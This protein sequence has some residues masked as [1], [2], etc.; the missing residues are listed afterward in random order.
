[1]SSERSRP[2]QL[3]VSGLPFHLTNEK[4]SHYFS[5]FGQI[6]KFTRPTDRRT[7]RNASYAFLS[8]HDVNIFESVRTHDNHCVDG[9]KFEVRL[10]MTKEEMKNKRKEESRGMVEVNEETIKKRYF[11]PNMMTDPW[12]H[13]K[14]VQIEKNRQRR[15]QNIRHRNRLFMRASETASPSPPP[16]QQ[17]QNPNSSSHSKLESSGNSPKVVNQQQQHHNQPKNEQIKTAKTEIGQKSH[18]QNET[19]KEEM[20]QPIRSDNR[21][22]ELEH[23]LK[24]TDQ[25]N[26]AIP[27]SSTENAETEILNE[28]IRSP[29]TKIEE[30][31]PVNGSEITSMFSGLYCGHIPGDSQ[32]DFSHDSSSGLIKLEY[33]VGESLIG[34]FIRIFLKSRRSELRFGPVSTNQ[35]IVFERL[36]GELGLDLI[37]NDDFL[38]ISR[39]Q[40]T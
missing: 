11:K 32:T 19:K 23:E 29:E 31:I 20:N 14:P 28:P 26:E 34:Y 4:L 22:V 17:Q 27:D 15:D 39:R 1:M 2:R 33:F 18:C 5:S 10:S 25:S 6:L 40:I 36:C 3:F 30:R 12:K 7:G 8:Y 13:C 37:L 35:R 24:N 16:P 21:D 38:T 9:I